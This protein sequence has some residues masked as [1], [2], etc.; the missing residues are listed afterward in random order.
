[1]SGDTDNSSVRFQT[2]LCCDVAVRI[3]SYMC[4]RDDDL[5]MSMYKPPRRFQLYLY[6]ASWF[7]VCRLNVQFTTHSAHI[8][9]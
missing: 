6:I 7:G 8:T 2:V 9:H 5:M 1:M 4:K 3:R